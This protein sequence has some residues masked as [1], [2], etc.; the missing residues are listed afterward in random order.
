MAGTWA[1]VIGLGS[2]LSVCLGA[3]LLLAGAVPT[4]AHGATQFSLDWSMPDRYGDA[5]GDGLADQVYPPDGSA[6]IDPGG[7]QVNLTV[8]GAACN[9]T[10]QR[11]WWIEG[12]KIVAGDPRLLS[13]SPSGCTLSYRVAQEGV[14]EVAF[15]ERDPQGTLLGSVKRAITVQDFLVV[16]VGD[17][18]ASGEG[19]PETPGAAASWENNSAAAA[20]CHRSR[21]AGP[22]QAALAL[23]QSDPHSS[24]TFIHLACSGATTLDGILGPEQ[25]GQGP[26]TVAQPPQIDQLKQ[27]VGNRE[28]DALTLSIGANDVHFS[29]LV[30]DCL[31]KSDCNLAAPGSAATRLQQA[32]PR[33]A[34]SYDQLAQALD[35]AGVSADRVYHTQYYD[36]THDDGGV[37]CADSI[38][39]DS[40]VKHVPGQPFSITA[41]E[42]SWASQTMMGGINN[43]V[44]ATDVRHN[45][46]Q[47]GG[48]VS[49]FFDHGYCAATHWIDTY[50]ESQ[51]LQGD[52]NGTLHPNHAGHADYGSRIAAALEN[53]LL[54]AGA[55]RKPFQR[56]VLQGEGPADTAFGDV[57][58]NVQPGA[59]V[60][61]RVQLNGDNTAFRNVSLSLTGPGSLS[62]TSGLTDSSGVVSV[63]YTA[64]STP[65]GCSDGPVCAVV[66]ATFTDAA[67]AHSDALSVGVNGIHATVT[68]SPPTATVAVGQMHLF[69]AQVTGTPDQSVTWSATGGT[70][71]PAGTYTAG[72]IPGTYTVT[73][74]SK[75]DPSAHDT[76][77]VQ[78]TAPPAG[79]TRISSEGTAS[80]VCSAIGTTEDLHDSPPGASF[81]TDAAQCSLSGFNSAGGPISGT[82]SANIS[83]TESSVNGSLT[84]VQATTFG[85]GSGTGDE[86]GNGIGGGQA[87]YQITFTLA[88]PTRIAIAASAS[89]SGGGGGTRVFLFCAGAIDLEYEVQN[90]IVVIDQIHG[91]QTVIVP[92]TTCAFGV[93]GGGDGDPFNGTGTGSASA[94]LTFG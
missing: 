85:T 4:A 30:K 51:S 93:G 90:G 94:D 3:A 42:A 40:P 81:W 82:A 48:F 52:D 56:I 2:L 64:P 44:M 54:P 23:E 83:F 75:V 50:T 32:L 43:E 33:L 84:S 25:P 69:G 26:V 34:G 7:W 12:L 49:D 74:T 14:V 57:V 73:A 17:S 10:T 13:A 37:I 61:L 79:V 65:T 68:V 58:G 53:D 89:A 41:A 92:A 16:S 8:T 70:I 19:N 59:S 63:A 91:S 21:Y 80:A 9:A 31:L 24:V 72:T 38:L 22:S 46:H 27:L 62:T 1:R 87:G 11:T 36:P 35:S 86:N 18:V 45:W 76:A 39:A 77:V 5:N 78:V 66:T 67:G 15:E 71:T 28:I 29:Q 20:Q 88:A 55:T 60:Q 47:V 6:V